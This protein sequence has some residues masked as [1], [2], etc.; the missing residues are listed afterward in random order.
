VGAAGNDLAARLA[1]RTLE[2]VNLQSLS[3]DEREIAA[4]V[5]DAMPWRA[6]WHTADTLW[7]APT[8]GGRPR[9]VLAGH[10]DTVPPQ[11]N[12]AG[13]LADGIVWG[14]GSSDM[15]GGLAVMIELARAW[16]DRRAAATLE[17]LDLAFLFFPREEAPAAENPLPELFEAIPELGA[18]DLAILLEPTDGAI[19]AGCLGHL[20]ARLVVEGRSAHSARPWLGVNAISLALERLAPIAAVPPREV[21]I[22]GLT[23]VEVLSVTQVEGGIAPNVVPDRVEATLSYRYAPDRTP[24]QAEEEL[25]R[26]AGKVEVVG[27]SP[28]GRVVAHGPLVDRLREAGALGLEPKQAWTNVADFTSRGVDAINFGPGKTSVVHA[29]DEHVEVTALV[30]AFE[31]LGRFAG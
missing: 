25:R 5:A 16:A 3:R 23:F 9:V 20:Q 2:L 12:L 4:Y 14:L 28:A 1:T 13:R 22:D 26:L 21:V 15:K 29:P 24:A 8:L 6:D 11:G 18:A 19:H 10:L 27:N 7:F 30:H 31:T 17:T